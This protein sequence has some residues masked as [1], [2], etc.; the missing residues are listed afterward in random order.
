M[1]LG[2][3]ITLTFLKSSSDVTL[4]GGYTSESSFALSEKLGMS[5]SLSVIVMIDY[6][7]ARR[8]STLVLPLSC[9]RPIVR[10]HLILCLWDCE[11]TP[12]D[13]RTTLSCARLVV[14]PPYS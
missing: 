5:Q 3:T 4:I 7:K 12:D 8:I 1:L 2:I 11:V 13:N 14:H 10:L 6:Q 9:I